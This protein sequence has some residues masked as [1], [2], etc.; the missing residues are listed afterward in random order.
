MH[1]DDD[2]LK[3]KHRERLS[4]QL[5]PPAAHRVPYTQ[6]VELAPSTI[7]ELFLIRLRSL[8]GPYWYRDGGNHDGE[9]GWYITIDMQGRGSDVDSFVAPYDHPDFALERLCHELEQELKV[10]KDLRNRK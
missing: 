1:F 7:D 8:R 5:P 10:R 3:Q 2:A 4:G 6:Y 9:D